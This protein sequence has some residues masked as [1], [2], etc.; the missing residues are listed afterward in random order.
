MLVSLIFSARGEKEC[1][2]Q[3]AHEL[4]FFLRLFSLKHTRRYLA[5]LSQ[6]IHTFFYKRVSFS[7]S[8]FFRLT[9][10]LLPSSHS[11]LT[12]LFTFLSFIFAPPF[13]SFYF[14]LLAF[15]FYFCLSVILFYRLFADNSFF[16]YLYTFSR[17]CVLVYL[18]FYIWYN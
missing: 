3:C 12:P 4:Q 6:I 8:L 5:F 9:F 17:F 15:Y 18:N 10:H 11:Y 7:F 13:N 2:K 14:S 1:N 16:R